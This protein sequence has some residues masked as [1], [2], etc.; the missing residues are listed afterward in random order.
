MDVRVCDVIHSSV[1]L[2]IRGK[3][4]LYLLVQSS[5]DLACIISV[6]L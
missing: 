1:A 5:F 4:L 6:S 3:D 2:C